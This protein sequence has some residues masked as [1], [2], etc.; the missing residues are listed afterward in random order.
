MCGQAE[1]SSIEPATVVCRGK[2]EELNAVESGGRACALYYPEN[3][4]DFPVLVMEGRVDVLR[5]PFLDVNLEIDH[6]VQEYIKQIFFSLMTAID[7]YYNPVQ[8]QILLRP[9][10][11]SSSANFPLGGTNKLEK[12]D[13]LGLN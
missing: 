4:V 5:S 3:R 6:T 12:R 11:P 8:W 2:Q 7:E 1:P 13:T 10:P 9:P